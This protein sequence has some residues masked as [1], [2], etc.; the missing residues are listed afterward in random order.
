MD[1]SNAANVMFFLKYSYMKF[2]FIPISFRFIGE[3][4]K[5]GMLTAPI[6]VRCIS[7][8]LNKDEEEGYECLCKLLTTIGKKLELVS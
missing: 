1:L 3:L 6:M 4:Y 7:D 5:L 8:L 2:V